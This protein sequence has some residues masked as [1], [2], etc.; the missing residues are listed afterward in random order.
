MLLNLAEDPEVAD[1][2]VR[3][4]WAYTRL[5]CFHWISGCSLRSSVKSTDAPWA[6][7]NG[8]LCRA[9]STCLLGCCS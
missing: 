4:V 7:E 5:P 8:T 6:D 1:L 3:K 9:S 2:M